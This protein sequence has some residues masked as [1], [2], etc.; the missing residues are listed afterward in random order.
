MKIQLTL[1]IAVAVLFTGIDST[2]QTVDPN[3]VDGHI[4]IKLS[5]ASPVNLDGYSG[6][7]VALD[8]LFATYGLDSIY[9]PFP[10]PGTALDSVYRVVFANAAQVDGLITVLDGLPYVEY[11]E[12]NPVAYEFHTPNDLQQIQWSLTKIQAE[13]GWNFSTGSSNVVIAVIDNAI[14]IDH[15][16]LSANIYTNTA[17][18][19]GLPFIDDD[20]NGYTDDVN[21]YD[22]VDGDNNP[23]PPANASGNGDGFIHGTHVAGIAGAVTNNGT[24]MA[25]IGYG[26]KIL[27]VKIARDSDGAMTGALDG[28]FY[29]TRTGADI[30]NMSFGIA[31]D[32]ATFNTIIT[33]AN[34]S[35]IVLV[36]AAGNDGT[37]DLHYPAAYPQV[38]SVGATDQNDQKASFS[39]YGTTIDVMAPGVSILSTLPEG[40]NTYGTSNGTSMASPM[41]AGLAG[42]VKSHFPSFSVQQIKD[43][44]IQGCV[45]VSA[46]NPGLDGLLGAGRIDAFG[47]L[48]NVS[49]PEENAL[50]DLSVYPNPITNEVLNVD[51]ASE[52]PSNFEKLVM[53][54][55]SGREVLRSTR[56]TAIDV[57]ELPPGT[58]LVRVHF[59]NNIVN[60]K[61]LVQ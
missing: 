5:D 18:A 46:Q 3:A 53:L 16:D 17:E 54:D 41:V 28:V 6:G 2:A 26:C 47:T 9:K 45:D 56:T 38:L 52:N 39:N 21:G 34:N 37:Q 7:N 44:I 13:L 61:V 58:Y 27:P 33:Q 43:R 59:E 30:I 35:G 10:L 15:E 25:S 19:G 23:R 4:H 50:S 42:L 40:N 31:G 55:V 12:K 36:A 20:L 60:R 1:L 8:L 49:I 32:V 24:G 29:A 14:A 11:A 48:G 57:S 22:V 51:L